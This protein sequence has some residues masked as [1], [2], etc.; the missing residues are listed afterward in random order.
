MHGICNRNGD[1]KRTSE[2][3]VRD[4]QECNPLGLGDK[5]DI[6][7]RLPYPQKVGSKRKGRERVYKKSVTL[8]GEQRQ[9]V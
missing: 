6:R 9:P 7:R 4:C 2:S 8:C 3:E 1:K 5:M